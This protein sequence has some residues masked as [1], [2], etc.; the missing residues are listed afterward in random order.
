MIK[1]HMKVPWRKKREHLEEG[2]GIQ[3]ALQRRPVLPV[4]SDDVQRGA[5]SQKQISQYLDT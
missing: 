4:F 2:V 5:R 1:L 3:R